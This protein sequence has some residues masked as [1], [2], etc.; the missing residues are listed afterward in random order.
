MME[1]RVTCFLAVVLLVAWGLSLANEP[2]T[3]PTQPASAPATSTSAPAA[4]LNVLCS[5]FPIYLFTR[6]VVAGR[7]HVR[8]GLLISAALGCPHDYVLTPQDMQAL[9]SAD[10]LIVNGLGMDEFLGGPL[11]KANPALKVVDSSVGLSDLIPMEGHEH[12]HPHLEELASRPGEQAGPGEAH[13]H[14]Q[15]VNPHLF[16]SPL[17]AAKV[18]R[19]IAKAMGELDP[20]GAAAYQANAQAYAAR[21]EKLAVDFSSLAS[22]LPNRKIVTQHAV[23]DYL[24]RD[25]G[26][27]IAAVVEETPGQEPSAAEMIELIRTIRSSGAAAV[28]TEPQY[29][30]KVAQTVAREAGVPVAVL[31]PVANGPNDAPLDYYEKVM[32]ENLRTLKDVLARKDGD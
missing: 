20:D 14:E 5:T 4:R 19:N 8:L 6:N 30:S 24:A 10:V 29:S 26:L 25:A 3:P 16:A 17:Q 1:T 27:V 21:L 2:T 13:E 18:V 32:A 9:A 12:T 11:K 31:D 15:A 7:E 23:F 22:M 28:F